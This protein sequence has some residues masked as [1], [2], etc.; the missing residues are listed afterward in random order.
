MA[1][2]SH[3]QFPNSKWS[4]IFTHY[5]HARRLVCSMQSICRHLRRRHCAWIVFMRLGEGA[6]DLRSS[7]KDRRC[8]SGRSKSYAIWRPCLDRLPIRSRVDEEEVICKS[9]D[10]WPR[11]SIVELSSALRHRPAS[12]RGTRTSRG[13]TCSYSYL[14]GPP[15]LFY[16]SL[17][18]RVFLN[19]RSQR[20]VSIQ[21]RRTVCT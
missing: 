19:N 15:H 17:A 2:V 8:A 16:T 7:P 3:G 21:S 6:A 12:C 14:T 9:E 20:T 1:C 4:L 11:C 13:I 10:P 18:N 5:I